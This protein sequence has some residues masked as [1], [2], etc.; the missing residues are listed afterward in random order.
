MI[1]YHG[2]YVIIAMPL[3]PWMQRLWERHCAWK[4]RNAQTWKRWL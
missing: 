3:L 1:L 2:T 4:A